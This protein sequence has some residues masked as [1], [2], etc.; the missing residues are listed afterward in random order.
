MNGGL[1]IVE[2]N[3]PV[4][5]TPNDVVTMGRLHP[6]SV[7]ANAT[8]QLTNPATA[9]GK[10]AL[11]YIGTQSSELYGL[12]I[13]M[14][15]T[16]A[17]FR[18]ASGTFQMDGG[19]TVANLKVGVLEVAD[20]YTTNQPASPMAILRKTQVVG[21]RVLGAKQVLVYNYSA[22]KIPNNSQLWIQDRLELITPGFGYLEAQGNLYFMKDNLNPSAGAKFLIPSVNGSPG[23]P[24]MNYMDTRNGID[25]ALPEIH[26]N[27]ANEF[28]FK[29]GK[30][31]SLTDRLNLTSGKVRVLDYNYLTPRSLH[32]NAGQ[33]DVTL[34]ANNQASGYICEGSLIRNFRVNCNGLCDLLFPMGE[35]TPAASG[36]GG[37]YKYHPFFSSTGNGQAGNMLVTYK[38]PIIPL[39][40]A[41]QNCNHGGGYWEMSLL[42]P[43]SLT[44]PYPNTALLAL[45]L[46]PQAVT[47]G[48]KSALMHVGGSWQATGGASTSTLW[49]VTCSDT[50]NAGSGNPKRYAVE[51]CTTVPNGN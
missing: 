5:N 41:S 24:W 51:R 36:G 12:T 4:V 15:T 38:K 16:Q 2:P 46:D 19:S 43:V 44:S 11:R 7:V 45:Q 26:I 21:G 13:H 30:T 40:P 10:V 28:E 47:T 27:V 50:Y 31:L 22:L 8:I 35:S 49:D 23:T 20:T 37:P 1:L 29:I 9:P 42:D 17:N 3:T 39:Y 18:P 48:T 32:V 25:F 34:N 14:G 33:V 6:N